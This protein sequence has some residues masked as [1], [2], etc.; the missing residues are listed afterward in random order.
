VILLSK[1]RYKTSCNVLH[2]F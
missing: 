2:H 1:F